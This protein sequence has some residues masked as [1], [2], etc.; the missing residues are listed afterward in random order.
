MCIFQQNTYKHFKLLVLSV[1]KLIM[2]EATTGNINEKILNLRLQKLHG[3]KVDSVKY[4]I[5][6][7]SHQA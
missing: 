3:D 4:D 1:N 5:L 7:Q 2:F 6:L